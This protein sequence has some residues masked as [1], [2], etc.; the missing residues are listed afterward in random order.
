MPAREDI[1]YF[2]AGPAALPT[3]VL[4]QASK[5]LLNFQDIGLGLGE[6]SHR[7]SQGQGVVDD[8]KAHLKELLH[9]P[10]SYDTVFFQGGGTGAFAAIAYLFMKY[11]VAKYNRVG[12]ANYIVTGGWSD[13]AAKEAVKLLGESNVQI[14]ADTKKS[15]GS[16]TS[17][18]SPDELSLS[19]DP[20]YVYYCDNE[21][22]HGVEPAADLYTGIDAPLVAD[23]SSNFLS[24]PFDIT[25]YAAVVAGAQKNVGIAGVTIA[26]IRKEILDAKIEPSILQ[27]EYGLPVAPTTL[28]LSILAANGSLYNTLP[29]FTLHVT[30]LT[31]RHL[32]AAGGLSEYGKKAQEKSAKIYSVID[33]YPE[34]YQCPV[35]KDCRSE[36][37]IVFRLAGG[38]AQEADFIKK[39]GALGISGIKGHRSV[40]GIRVS[41]YNAIQ[42]Q[43][44]DILVDFMRS[45]AKAE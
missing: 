40:G 30:D 31:L 8:A 38:D 29:I 32:I 25:K 39:A 17:V 26:I 23:M 5:D 3:S 16:W 37:N 14:A 1:H 41:N 42:D 35:K 2:G 19:A 43:S 10:D 36:M 4:E 15:T 27:K 44:V 18:P 34:L 11:H 21:T 20:A 12:Q 45:Y 9:I 28:D 13:K 22:V 6:I 24:R 33:E 7:S